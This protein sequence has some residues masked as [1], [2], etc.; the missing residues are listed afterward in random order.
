MIHE[1]K[2]NKMREK[3]ERSKE[4]SRGKG[5]GKE[6]ERELSYPGASLFNTPVREIRFLLVK[7]QISRGQVAVY[8]KALL[9]KVWP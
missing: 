2:H 3:E 1:R 4:R 5:R 6:R 9:F 8:S 7:D